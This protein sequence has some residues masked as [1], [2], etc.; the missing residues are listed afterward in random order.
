MLK[1]RGCQSL[2]LRIALATIS[3]RAVHI[4]DIRANSETPG[5]RDFEANFLRLIEKVTNGCVVEINETGVHVSAIQSMQFR[6]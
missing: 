3:G 4:D 1:F 5:L 2:R 6:E